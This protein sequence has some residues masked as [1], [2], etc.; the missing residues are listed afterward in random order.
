[1]KLESVVP[2][3]RSKSEY[4]RMF[5]LTE[6]DLNKKILGC[7]DGPSSFNSEL[8]GN[9]ISIDPIYGFS[10]E[11]INTRIAETKEIIREQLESNSNDFLWNEFQNV[12]DLCNSRLTSMANF[13]EDYNKGKRE[14]RYVK[15]SLPYLPVEAGRFQLALSSHFLFLYSNDLDLDFHI[16]SI[17]EMLRVS[18]EVRI[19]PVL[20]LNGKES[21]HLAG[22]L[23]Y[24][25]KKKIKYEIKK[26]MYEFQK[27]ADAVLN[28]FSG[29]L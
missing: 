4:I 25:D 23:Q 20:D 6:D 22:V 28:I 10:K 2:W 9:A 1:M 12:D 13:L 19:F 16:K 3:G 11:E 5:L 29:G 17:I 15:G 21:V 14:G 24:L 26:S 7:G 18:E 27:G 8:N